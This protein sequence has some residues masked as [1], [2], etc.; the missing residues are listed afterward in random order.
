VHH[1]R[2][3]LRVSVVV[4]MAFAVAAVWAAPALAHGGSETNTPGDGS[5]YRPSSPPTSV[6]VHFLGVG[7][8]KLGFVRVYDKQGRIVNARA[9]LTGDGTTVVGPLPKLG[10]GNYVVSWRVIRADAHPI[11]GAFTFT[12]KSQTP[13]GNKLARVATSAA[14]RTPKDNSEWAL[15]I[16][17]LLLGVVALAAITGKVMSNR[18]SS[19]S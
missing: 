2:V 16:I 8:V 15:V 3:R 10:A 4:C 1:W 14:P 11:H 19:A 6:T 17:A 12:V 13:N 7:R 9:H 5:T 18:R